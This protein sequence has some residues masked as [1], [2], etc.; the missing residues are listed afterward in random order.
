M[1]AS[2]LACAQSALPLMVA[3]LNSCCP[4]MGGVL[5]I[6]FAPELVGAYQDSEAGAGRHVPSPRFFG[7]RCDSPTSRSVGKSF[8]HDAADSALGPL[9]IVDTQSDAVAIP[10][11]EF[12]EVTVKVL[13]A[14]VLIDAVDSALQDREITF[15]GISRGIPPNVFLLCMVDGAVTGEPFASLPINAALVSAQVRS[16]VDFGFKDGP[17]V[18]CVHFGDVPRADPTLSFNERDDSFL[19]RWSF[20]GPVPRFAADKGFV[21]LDEHAL[22]PKWATRTIVAHSFPDAMPDEPAGFEIDAKDAG[23]LICAEALLAAA[24]QMHCLQPRVHRNVAFLE[25]GADFDG[26]RLPAGI[27]F[28]D[29][30]AGALAFQQPAIADHATM[31]TCAPVRPDDCLDVSVGSFFVAEPDSI[32]TR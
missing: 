7:L 30:D 11:V 32:R 2:A 5:G 31:R 27:A 12:G 15:C 14:H 20:V 21:C 17:Q 23:E 1:N 26:E 28:V 24:Q 18:R 13:F 22:A 8:A 9:N 4:V 6:R 3:E 19:G 10:E 29:A 25:N 16:N